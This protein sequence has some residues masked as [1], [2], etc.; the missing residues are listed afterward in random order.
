MY[1]IVHVPTGLFIHAT[2]TK[3]NRSIFFNNVYVDYRF[4]HNSTIT[5][6]K[7]YVNHI[8]S[9]MKSDKHVLVVSELGSRYLVTID[10][11]EIVEHR[12]E[13]LRNL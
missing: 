5:F 9:Q 1:S 10:E 2:I 6:S 8:Y 13:S 7:S 4:Q 3:I 11:F 12:N